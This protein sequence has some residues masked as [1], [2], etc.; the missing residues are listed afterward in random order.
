M[1]GDWIKIEHALPDKPEVW[2]I[3]EDLGLDPDAVVGKLIRMWVWFD[4]NTHNGNAPSVTSALLDRHVGVQDFVKTVQKAG[5]IDVVDDRLV[6]KNF[7]RHNGK[8]AKTRAQARDRQEEFR[9]KNK[10]KTKPSQNSNAES[11]TNALLEKRR[12]ENKKT[13]IK[14]VDTPN[15]EP[16]DLDAAKQIFSRIHQLNPKAK[17]P[18]IK[19]WAKDIRLMRERDSRS[20]EDIWRVFDWANKDSFWQGNILSPKKLRAKYDQLVMQMQ[21]QPANR[22]QTAVVSSIQ[23]GLDWAENRGKS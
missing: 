13:K 18:N 8:T 5:W 21:R 2:Q 7:A 4:N 23:T 14:Q 22:S 17:K 12:E 9:N 11:V 1:A 20:Y 19:S 10:D 3:A 6:V 15:Y 16:R